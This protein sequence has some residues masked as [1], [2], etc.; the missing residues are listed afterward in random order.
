MDT[1]KNLESSVT[2]AELNIVDKSTMW[3]AWSICKNKEGLNKFETMDEF[4]ANFNFFKRDFIE[5]VTGLKCESEN[6]EDI[7]A[8]NQEHDFIM[9]FGLDMW[10][11]GYS[12][13]QIANFFE[14]AKC[15]DIKGLVQ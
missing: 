10:D 1:M 14:E 6:L 11:K 5:K 13:P 3:F 2:E 4:C 12:I 15:L 9:V 7:K 8:F